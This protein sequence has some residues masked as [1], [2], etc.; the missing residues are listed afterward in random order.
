[1][2]SCLVL[3]SLHNTT[4]SSSFCVVCFFFFFLRAESNN[5][6]L[7]NVFQ[8]KQDSRSIVFSHQI[9]TLWVRLLSTGGCSKC[10]NLLIV[11]NCCFFNQSR[12]I[13]NLREMWG[14][15]ISTSYVILYSL[16][17]PVLHSFLSIPL[18]KATKWNLVWN[19]AL[20]N[21]SSVDSRTGYVTV[22]NTQNLG[23]IVGLGYKL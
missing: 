18:Q 4:S 11:R 15:A 20:K 5:N 19:L 23:S 10:I 7:T 6:K 2:D 1:M 3:F 9:Y 22:P 14:S 13:E 16:V 17:S 21:E 8:N 12:K